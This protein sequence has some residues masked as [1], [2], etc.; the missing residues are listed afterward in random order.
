MEHIDPKN[1]M[2]QE[3]FC[4]LFE[5]LPLTDKE[6]TDVRDIYWPIYKVC[7]DNPE[8][9]PVEA[10][11]ATRNTFIAKEEQIGKRIENKK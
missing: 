10:W 2:S 7:L 4:E 9:P 1:P 5:Q 3:Q 11:L 8:V 6:R